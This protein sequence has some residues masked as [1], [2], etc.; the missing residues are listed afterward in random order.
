MRLAQCA[1][2]ICESSRNRYKTWSYAR[3]KMSTSQS[4]WIQISSV[5]KS[6]ISGKAYLN[7]HVYRC[8]DEV[9]APQWLLLK[10]STLNQL[11]STV[12]HQFPP[13]KSHLSPLFN[14]PRQH[15]RPV[16]I[17]YEAPPNFVTPPYQ[18]TPTDAR[19]KLWRV[20]EP[21]RIVVLMMPWRGET[22]L[23]NEMRKCH[24]LCSSVGRA[25]GS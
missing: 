23:I 6:R 10:L 2:H 5:L 14:S 25:Y 3:Y 13:A 12:N 4:Y 15:I 20:S 9:R 24:R 22:R 19:V 16:R 17:S 7:K 11:H 8:V 18:S 1:S 21:F